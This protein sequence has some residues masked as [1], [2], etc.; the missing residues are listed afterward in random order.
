MCFL[1]LLYKRNK[2]HKEDSQEQ[3]DYST[4]RNNQSAVG[5]DVVFWWIGSLIYCYRMQFFFLNFYAT[6]H[7]KLL[8]QNA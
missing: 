2:K 4:K 3:T 1:L 7:G 5:F 6:Q 8:L